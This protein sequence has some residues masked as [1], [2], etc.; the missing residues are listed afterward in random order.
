MF[1]FLKSKVEKTPAEKT[2]LG[3]GRGYIILNAIRFVNLISLSLVLAASSIM[4]V[5]TFIV[6]KFFFFDAVSHVITG[7]LS[8][9]LMTTE[10]GLFNG[11]FSKHWPLLSLKSGFVTL[12]IF[13]IVVGVSILGNLNK[14]ATSQQSLGMSFWQIVICSGILTTIMGVANIVVSYIFRDTGMDVTARMIRKWGATEAKHNVSEVRGWGASTPRQP[15][16]TPEI[17]RSNTM[18][19]TSTSPKSQVGDLERGDS[20]AY[21]PNVMA[22]RTSSYGSTSRLNRNISGPMNVDQDQF[23]KF[24]GQTEEIRKPDMARHPAFQGERF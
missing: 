12:G 21:R 2:K 13:M 17:A 1:G 20:R 16:S 4:I 8:I 23:S 9:F 5:K 11:Y 18:Y 7:L 6:S 15:Y 3:R 19:S 14:D 24:K 22:S 10:V